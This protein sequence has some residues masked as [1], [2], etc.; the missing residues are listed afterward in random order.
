MV[1]MKII[2][3]IKPY[4]KVLVLFITTEL[5]LYFALSWYQHIKEKEYLNNFTKNIQSKYETTLETFAQKAQIAYTALIDTDSVKEM[6]DKTLKAPVYDTDK[7]RKALYQT[8]SSKYKKLRQFGFNQVQFHTPDNHSLLRL[9]APDRYGDDLSTFRHTVVYVNRTHRPI[10]SFEEGY[11]SDGYRFVFPLFMKNR[12]L[13]SVELSF[14]AYTLAKYLQN[15]FIDTHFIIDKKALVFENENY[16]TS[17]ISPDFVIDLKHTSAETKK[18]LPETLP[19]SAFL[20]QN[21]KPLSLMKQIDD[22]TYVTTLIPVIHTLTQE[23]QAYMLLFSKSPYLNQLRN[24]F[25]VVFMMFSVVLFLILFYIVREKKLQYQIKKQNVK[26]HKNYHKLKTILDTQENMIVITDG[27]QI[28]DVNKKVL[29]FFGYSSLQHLLR[30]HTCICDFFIRHREYFHLG[31]VPEG[32]KWIDYITTLPVKERVVTMVG[33]NMEAKAF[34]VNISKYDNKGS[35]I[36]SF[37]DVTEMVIREKILR[38][39]AQ[40]DRLTDIFNRQKLDEVLEKICGFS[41]RRKE[42]TGVILFDIDHFKSINDTYG[43]ATGDKV[44]QVLAQTVK[45]LIRE[46]DI[47]GRWGGEEFLIILR[48]ASLENSYK[49]AQQLREA[50]EEISREDIPPFTA[51]FG[52]TQIIPGDSPESL[53][54]RVDIAL[55]KAKSEGRNRVVLS[56]FKKSRLVLTQS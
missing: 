8:L 22:T 7:R 14:P 41:T 27:T 33:V 38:Y 31:C 5:I 39:K 18:L 56:S 26:L 47:F 32:E 29:E 20:L 53:L 49:K 3:T 28:A 24:S 55:Y 15:E 6:V 11:A 4:S 44:L 40:H 46:E 34:Q 25:Q 36:I 35:A 9:H 1:H 45:K 19:N 50:V 43:H 42:E 54:K 13:C 30:N 48:H 12:Y 10:S 2:E 23:T 16:L 37:T 52:V 17:S 21:K 51:S